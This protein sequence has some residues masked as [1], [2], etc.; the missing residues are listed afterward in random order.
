MKNFF[1]KTKESSFSF[2]IN[3]LCDTVECQVEEGEERDCFKAE[4]VYSI[5]WGIYKLRRSDGTW[6]PLKSPQELI[7]GMNVRRLFRRMLNP[8]F[9]GEPVVRFKL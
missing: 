5:F 3:L 4:A 9:S 6:V 8:G 2:L 1:L 7:L